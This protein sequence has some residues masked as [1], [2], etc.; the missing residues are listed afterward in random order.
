MSEN[1][2]TKSLQVEYAPYLDIDMRYPLT[3]SNIERGRNKSRFAL[4]NA[5]RFGFVSALVCQHVWCLRRAKVLEFLGKLV[6]EGYLAQVQTERAADG[7]IYVLTHSGARFASELMRIEV[8]FRSTREPI[9]QINQKTIVKNL[10][11]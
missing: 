5:A 3:P 8:P 1:E 4:Q 6:S 9:T 7:R 11:L 2:S 10:I